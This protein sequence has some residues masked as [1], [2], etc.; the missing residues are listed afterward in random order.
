MIKSEIP[1]TI[2][3]KKLEIVCSYRDRYFEDHSL[4]DAIHKNDDLK[5]LQQETIK[6]FEENEA[7][8]MKINKALYF[9][10]KGALLNVLPEYNV[11]AENLL[12][13]AIKLDR[14]LVEA[15]N[16]LGDCYWKNDE[17]KKSKSC[18]EGALKEVCNIVSQ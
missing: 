12:S 14:K 6:I 13:K 10:L 4:Q 9:F 1:N 11:D 15:W 8:A 18:F 7:A 2:F 5:K 16:E 3:Q 17:F